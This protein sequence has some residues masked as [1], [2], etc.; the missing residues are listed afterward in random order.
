MLNCIFIAGIS[1]D[2]ALCW[3]RWFMALERCNKLAFNN[4]LLVP[5]TRT[6]SCCCRQFSASA[7]LT[8]PLA[9]NNHVSATKNLFRP[10]SAVFRCERLLEKCTCNHVVSWSRTVQSSG[11]LRPESNW[12]TKSRLLSSFHHSSDLSL[13]RTFNKFS[14]TS[15]NVH[16]SQTVGLNQF[17]GA[18]QYQK[19]S[20]SGVVRQLV[21]QLIVFNFNLFICFYWTVLWV[22]IWQKVTS[23]QYSVQFCK[24]NCGFWFGFRFAI[25]T[26]VL[27]FFWFG[28]LCC[29]LCRFIILLSVMNY[30]V[31][32]VWQNWFFSNF[33]TYLITAKFNA[34]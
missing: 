20:L 25:F 17:A 27:V 3:T 15:K 1:V 10:F 13:L 19:W 9:S 24:K 26:A 11:Y 6:L 18:K 14:A 12:V 7:K 28:F 5:V 22:C 21:C 16:D 34:S 31:I 32:S 4:I 30:V 8:L 33:I 23:A 29:L 2:M